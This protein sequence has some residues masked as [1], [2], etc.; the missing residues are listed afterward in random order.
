MDMVYAETVDEF[1]FLLQG[2]EQ[3]ESRS[4]LLQDVAR[5]RPESD[6]ST[7]LAFLPCN[8]LQH[9]QDSPVSGMYSVEKTSRGYNHLTSSIS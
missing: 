5:M 4:I 2:V 9:L 3:A 8:I 7:L 1:S 6:D